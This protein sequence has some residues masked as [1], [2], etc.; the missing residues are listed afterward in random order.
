M[1]KHT[2]NWIITL[3]FFLLIIMNKMN[4][5]ITRLQRSPVRLT[6][7]HAENEPNVSIVIVFLLVLCHSVSR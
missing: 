5:K 4:S 1:V 7:L 2:A 6:I 3:F